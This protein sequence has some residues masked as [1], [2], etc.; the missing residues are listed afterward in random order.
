MTIRHL[1]VFLTVCKQGS[2]TKAAEALHTVQPSVSQTISELEK[3]YGIVLFDRIGRRLVLTDFGRQLSVKAQEAVT[4]FDE[5]ETFAHTA[6]EKPYVRV[7]SS[8]TIGRVLLPKLF[9]SVH[10]AHPEIR[11]SAVVCPAAQLEEKL[12]AGRVDL[13]LL[14]G[15]TSSPYLRH[16]PFARDKL[17]AV[18]A[19]SFP[20]TE[21]MTLAQLSNC[22]LLLREKGSASR[23]FID[24]LFALENLHPEPVVESASNEAILSLAAEGEGI[25]ILPQALASPLLLKGKLCEITLENVCLVREYCIAF[26][27]DKH[28]TNA[29]K[30]VYEISLALTDKQ[31]F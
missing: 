14:E 26:H 16:I 4:A 19:H 29:Q 7:G 13:A 2:I 25:A 12:L 15:N 22:K 30:E 5:F 17:T 24:S 1:R 10:A 6:E 8:L 31:T 3:H 27:K 21:K 23:D 11:L 28:F 20:A 18:C 9:R